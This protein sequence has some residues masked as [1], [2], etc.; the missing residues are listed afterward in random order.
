MPYLYR[1]TWDPYAGPCGATRRRR[2]VRGSPSMH[3]AVLSAYTSDYSLGRLTEPVNRQYAERHGYDF[4]CVVHPPVGD[5]PERH[6]TWNKVALITELLGMLLRGRGDAM[7]IA[8]STTHLLWV[9][10]DA[11]VLQHDVTVES[12]WA[13]LPDS[14]ELLI[15]EDVT[16]ACPI[17]AGVLCV[18]VSE[19]SLALWRDVWSSPRS[20]KFYN[21]TYHE[22]SALLRQLAYRGE[23]LDFASKQPFHSYAGGRAAP[24]V[25]P[26]VC[27]LPRHAFNTNHCDLRRTP[28]ASDRRIEDACHF[29]FHAAGQP[30]LRCIGPS[31]VSNAWKPT[32]P[33]ALL[34]ALAHVGLHSQH[35]AADRG[36]ALPE[37]LARSVATPS[38]AAT[39]TGSGITQSRPH[40]SSRRPS[41]RAK[42]PGRIMN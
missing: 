12:L 17:N 33:V 22:Q 14:I 40:S 26:H 30:C 36:A 25:F 32:K 16:P 39:A 1:H 41:F 38:L 29:I 13:G 37:G 24:K 15:G 4:H 35:E 2:R 21:R 34:A 7:P 20:Q 23:G 19:W 10:A 6:P 8:E 28:A 11:V 5:R 3:V 27:V 18:R 9:D 31:G 42:Y